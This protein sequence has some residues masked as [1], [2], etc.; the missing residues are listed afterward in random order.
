MSVERC[1]IDRKLR[2]DRPD[3]LKAKKSVEIAEDGLKEAQK[4]ADAAFPNQALV[5]AYASMFHA[6]RALLYRDGVIEKSYFCLLMYLK[7]EYADKGK[8]DQELMTMMDA[9]REERHEIFYSL[10]R[11]QISN[12]DVKEALANAKKLLEKV[13]ENIG[14]NLR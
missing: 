13:K 12:D 6:G 8:L 2:H 4:L 10:N 11:V 14:K 1:F 3:L 9:F 5:M 7:E